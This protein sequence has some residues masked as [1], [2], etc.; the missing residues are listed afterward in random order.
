M[1]KTRDA[2]VQTV[3]TPDG[4]FT[5]I[6]DDH[7][8]VLASGWSDDHQAVW[9]RIHPTIRP[10]TL[11]EG[12]TEAGEAVS[13]YYSGDLDAVTAVPVRQRG[14]ELQQ[15]G[16][17]ALREIPPGEPLSYTGFALLL[18]RAAAVRPAA[19][20][21]ARNAPALFVPCHRVL[22]TDGALG[23][24][25]WGTAVK[26]SLLDHEQSLH[27]AP[28]RGSQG[29]TRASGSSAAGWSGPQET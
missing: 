16:W 2:T 9:G 20:I 7:G 22:R 24:F 13:A 3:D 18:G 15:R 29:G 27:R 6:T 26:R 1:T 12:T 14:T 5:L 25:A 8:Q 11:V 4:A 21:C 10:R 19:S 23:G 28:E 17:A